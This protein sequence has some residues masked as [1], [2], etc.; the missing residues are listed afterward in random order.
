MNET[1]WVSE[2]ELDQIQRRVLTLAPDSSY[3]VSGPPGSGK[4]N[5]LLLRAKY[6]SLT[7]KP[8]IK[9][10]LFTRAL[11]EFIASGATNYDFR[12]DQVQ[13]SQQF[14]IDLLYEYGQHIPRHTTFQDQ[15]RALVG[16]VA[17]LVASRAISNLYDTVLIDEAHDF[18]PEEIELFGKLGGTLFAV[19]DARQKIYGG[20]A[21]FSVIRS[22]IDEEVTLTHHYRN[23]I[24]ICRFADLVAKDSSLYEAISP[25][26]NYDD[27]ARPSSVNSHDCPN[28]DAQIDV[29]LVKL[30]H[31]LVAYPDEL[32]GIVSP[33]KDVVDHIWAAILA[34]GYS[35]LSTI[36]RGD[37][38]FDFESGARIGVSTLHAVKGL[39]FRALHVIGCEHF[40]RRPFPRSLAFTAAT[41]AKTTLD[42]YYSGNLLGFLDQAV[43]TQ[44]PTPTQPTVGDLF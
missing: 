8:N 7:G 2:N 13:T 39:E 36:Q 25:S 20:E 40:R 18:W 19:A 32:I 15:R 28:L 35:G 5:L 24:S 38:N 1:W 6:L 10:V 44:S 3:L 22:L 11:R 27:N 16:A 37:E 29:M 21:P 42:L 31:Q 30:A 23:G 41:R 17:K 4:T 12:R 34:G 43:S 26:C 33:S 14:W 9:L